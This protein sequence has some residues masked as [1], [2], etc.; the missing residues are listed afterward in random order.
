MGKQNKKSIKKKQDKKSTPSSSASI[1][2]GENDL[3]SS[4][5]S[6]P[7]PTTTTAPTLAYEK[8]KV[9]LLKEIISL[10]PTKLEMVWEIK[11]DDDNEKQELCPICCDTV[12]VINETS[13]LYSCCGGMICNRCFVKHATTGMSI[14]GSGGSGSSASNNNSDRCPLCRADISDCS[15]ATEIARI[16]ERANRDGNGNATANA[17]YN[18]GGYYDT[19]NVRYNIQQDQVK[20]RYWYKKAA[21]KG[22]VRAALNLACCFRDGDGGVIDH[23]EALKYLKMAAAG[24]HIPGI[25]NLG[26]AY[27]R[28]DGTKQDLEE[29]EKWLR[30]GASR[31][32]VLAT[33]QLD[34]LQMIKDTQQLNLNTDSNIA[35]TSSF[36]TTA[37]DGASMFSFTAARK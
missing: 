19:G 24:G 35:C 22:E 23:V 29:A 1:S 8:S 17:C 33:Q 37:S 7:V 28:G 34:V 15:D 3:L 10:L 18:L 36:G 30:V 31:G 14:G 6:T 25:T 5:P 12:M 13:S 27:M 32:D 11:K 16:R 2:A 21:L 4:A 26:L 9:G 20:A